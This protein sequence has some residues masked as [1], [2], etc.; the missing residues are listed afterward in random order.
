MS[1]LDTGR[2]RISRDLVQGAANL[3][4]PA[5]DLAR[6]ASLMETAS[7]A[8]KG[9]LLDKLLGPTALFAGSLVGV[10][11][12][13]R[14]VVRESGILEKGMKRIATVQGLSGKFETLLR[15]A[16][17]AKAK[18]EELYRFTARSPFDF[19]DV[20]QAALELEKLTRGAFTGTR[21]MQLVG[22]AAA[23]TGNS[24]TEMS[25]VLGRLY[26]ALS[27]GRSI[28]RILFQFQG[29]GVVTD[30][31]AA[32]LAALEASGASFSSKWA[33]V[34]KVLGR[35]SGGM[36]NEMET[37][38]ALKTRLDQANAVFAQAFAAPY[39]EAQVNAMKAMIAATENLTPV[40][41]EIGRDFSV[42][43]N[44]I[45]D[46][47]NSLLDTVAASRGFADALRVAYKLAV[48]LFVGLAGATLVAA[49]RN[50]AGLGSA[51]LAT[52][53][54]MRAGYAAAV[55]ATKAQAG[56]ALATA[57]ADSANKAFAAGNLFSAATLKA[58]SV[59]LFAKTRALAA[60]AAAARLAGAGTASYSIASHAAGL[61]VAGLGGAVKLT[62]KAF[63]LVAG[64]IR[65]SIVAFAT[66]PWTAGAFAVLTLAT[67]LYKW[68]E[69][70]RNAAQDAR[71]LA[72]SIRDTNKQLTEQSAAV[73]TLTD[74][75][76]QVERLRQ[77]YDEA[78][79]AVVAF[80]R[81][82][83]SGEEPTRE[84]IQANAKAVSDRSAYRAALEKELRRNTRTLGLTDGETEMIRADQ[85]NRRAARDRDS[86]IA[87]ESAQTPEQKLAL[88]ES[89]KAELENRV[90]D[91]RAAKDAEFS[92]LRS[93]EAAR[94][95][96]LE[97]KAADLRASFDQQADLIALRR[98]KA[99]GEAGAGTVEARDIWQEAEKELR[100]LA[101]RRAAKL[102]PVEADIRN[103]GLVSASPTVR[104]QAQLDEALRKGAGPAEVERLTRALDDA[105]AA[106]AGLADAENELAE[107]SAQAERDGRE[108]GRA[109]AL[110]NVTN[111]FDARIT[112]ARRAGLPAGGLEF[113]KAIALAEV[114]RNDAQTP[115]DRQAAQDKIDALN[116]ERE[117][118]RREVRRERERNAALSRRDRKSAQAMEDADAMRAQRERYSALGLSA[119]EADADFRASLLA[120]AAG[121]KPALVADSRA[122]IG[123]GGGVFQGAD[124]LLSAIER[125]NRAQDQIAKETAAAAVLLRE[126]RDRITDG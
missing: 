93:G 107:V 20:A 75:Q 38:D 87:Y 33:E 25:H 91:G 66:N 82:V 45:R 31:L 26:D 55:A 109:R 64:I 120:Q 86:R 50:L 90:R 34:E 41:A 2:Q 112:E 35:T 126:I 104:A 63:A 28:D 53:S 118:G 97:Q 30:E 81:K 71:E 119:R 1:E 39:V 83:A 94:R 60:N 57:L 11:R 96:G 85:A 103:L 6:G 100:A 76:T 113:D 121:K 73:K 116:A 106:V 19:K 101:V 125:A 12:T 48:S 29:T 16:T 9:A 51:T 99:M 110:Q 102:D 14:A 84:E 46:A 3:A 122:A 68:G 105:K 67:A 49:A 32:K 78:T 92:A 56:L 80:N 15:S 37:L 44:F 54:A 47:K 69:A 61:A 72:D 7:N 59:W 74:W 88:L 111:Q 4:G 77:K 79:A 43:P 65:G 23:A 114:E 27:R 108:L 62:G 70:A 124:P 18:I 13:V 95:V 58:E 24:M 22:D 115:E 8:L 98:D 17:A 52:A 5:A 123:G 89:R 10:L 42:V 40:V 21:A 36:R 117:A